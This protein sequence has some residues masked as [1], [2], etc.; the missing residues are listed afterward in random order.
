MEINHFINT[1]IEED[2]RTGKHEKA[3]T[4]FPPEPNGFLHLG[5]A[6][7]IITNYSMA[8]KHGGYFNLRFDDTN[9]VKEDITFVDAIKEDIAWL[10]CKWENLFYA[11]DYFDEMYERALLL[12]RRGKA[13]VCDLTPDEIREYRGDFKTP[14]KE[15]PYR[16]R[17]IE[18]NLELFQGMKNGEF[19][20]GSRVL[21]AKID[22]TSPNINLRDP[23]L[24]RIQRA[25][26]HNTGDTWCIYPMYDY[27]HP[28][29]D[30]IEGI[31]HSLCSL[32][33]EDHRPLYDWVV[34][35][36]EMKY[37]P[38]Q[39]EFGK[40]YIAGAVTG[41]RHIKKLVED[42][43]VMG[44]DDP[45]LITLSG[46]RRR[47]IP[48]SAIRDFVYSLGLPKSQ[49][50]TEMDML[51]QFVRDHLKLEAP[52]INAVIEPLKIII[53]NYPEDEVEY[54]EAENNRENMEMGSRLIPFSKEVYIEREDFIEE[55][56][57]K[58][59]K[60]LALGVEVRLMHAYFI[61]ANSVVKDELGNIIEVHCTYDKDTK[62]GSG[63]T[64]RKPNGNIHFVDA[65]HCKMAEF[66]LL[67][68]LITDFDNKDIPFSEK[69]NKDSLIVKQGYVE[70]SMSKEVGS[71]YQFTRNGYYVCDQDSTDELLVYNRIV[72]LKSSFK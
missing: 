56:P 16:N 61:K 14:G 19:E 34:D 22:M 9:P 63:F 27:A 7:A 29:E 2:I 51:Y 45:R 59:W 8:E 69:V 62:S 26:H 36:C 72:S 35:N 68:D 23:I 46:L 50:E 12:I 47:G 44:W 10:G 28:L 32:E 1:I 43:A 37:K 67:D 17:T 5:H 53:D 41:K 52:R 39:I 13:Y 3:I 66:R 70:E 40:L 55:K 58:K 71:K 65:K 24:Y 31:T 18:E 57:N 20:D 21:R 30:A 64:D 48:A 25:H 11:S 42:G 49:G 6:R 60:R 15:S 33:F 4:R 54:L 38:R